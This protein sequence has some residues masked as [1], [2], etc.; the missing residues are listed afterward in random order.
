LQKIGHVN[1]TR[2][3]CAEAS[4]DRLGA[5]IVKAL[6]TVKIDARVVSRS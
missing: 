6:S 4:N 5:A 2:A 1:R 3:A